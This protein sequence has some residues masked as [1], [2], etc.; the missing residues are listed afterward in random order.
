[1]SVEIY[2]QSIPL[3]SI[4]SLFIVAE[5]SHS[6]FFLFDSLKSFSLDRFMIKLLQF[7]L[8]SSYHAQIFEHLMYMYSSVTLMTWEIVKRLRSQ[9]PY[10]LLTCF[11]LQRNVVKHCSFLSI[12][13]MCPKPIQ[14]ST[15]LLIKV[16][17]PPLYPDLGVMGS[18]GAPFYQDMGVSSVVIIIESPNTFSPG[19]LQEEV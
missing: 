14:S 4:C 7:S 19:F 6:H 13:S 12:G 17:L 15:S 5:K 10:F 9:T 8:I 16:N 11:L 2:E 3:S 18:M 1:M